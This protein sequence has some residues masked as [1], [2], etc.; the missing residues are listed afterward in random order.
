[1][2]AA[3]HRFLNRGLYQPL[4][5]AVNAC[6]LRYLVDWRSRSRGAIAPL[7]VDAGCGE[8]YYLARLGE[9]IANR[10]I[11]SGSLLS[12][13]DSSREAIR[14]AARRMESCAWLVADT[15]GVMPYR[16]GAASLL[17][18]IFAPRNAAQFARVTTP[19]GHLVVVIP[20]DR[21]LGE[22]REVVPL[23]GIQ[24]GKHDHVRRQLSPEFSLQSSTLIEY[25]I[26]LDR[27][28]V[29]DLIRMTP[30]NWHL[31]DEGWRAID[32]ATELR[33]LVSC[34]LLVFQRNAGDAGS[35]TA[36]ATR[37]APRGRRPRRATP[38][39]AW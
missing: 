33:T 26:V 9:M 22:L 38:P 6:A 16:S 12:G 21:H 34:E 1:M 32:R 23:I 30:S 28:S 13:F 17:I 3:R 25:P 8:G 35:T 31:G 5:D 11:L 24:A 4:S 36:A 37:A 19:G 20:T 2:V 39:R 29:A 27:M 7:I 15:R 10:A 18:N 14:Q